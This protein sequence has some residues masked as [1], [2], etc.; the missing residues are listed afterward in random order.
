MKWSWKQNSKNKKTVTKTLL[1]RS[2]FIQILVI[3][4]YNWAQIEKVVSQYQTKYNLK[5]MNRNITADRLEWTCSSCM[6]W[7]WKQNS[8]NK[9]TVTKTLLFRSDFIQI[10]LI[11]RYNWAQTEKV[12]SQYQTKYITIRIAT[13]AI[14][15]FM[16]Y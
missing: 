6:K 16:S 11:F 5:K 15:S 4:R 9:K 7:S 14:W 12:V 1:F 8:K 2:E 13:P 10:L 3:F